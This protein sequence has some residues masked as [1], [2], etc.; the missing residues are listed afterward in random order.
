MN[1][2]T[3]TATTTTTTINDAAPT[4]PTDMVRIQTAVNKLNS[5]ADKDDLDAFIRGGRR[6]ILLVDVS[7]SMT[8]R[9]RAGGRKIDALRKVVTTLR[10]TH[11]V[12]VAAF[13]VNDSYTGVA[14]IDEVPEPQGSTPMD[15]AID[16]GREQGANHLVIV[17][18]GQPNDEHSTMRAAKAFGNP[19]DVFYVG[20]GSGR[21]FAKRLATM[22][23]GE[24]QNAD[25]GAIKALA[26]GIRLMLGDGTN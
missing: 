2:T 21:E 16:F 1:N 9:L 19:I 25:L 26:S 8:D 15:N 24:F 23:G 5:S 12:P 14:L 20:D 10:E 6:S 13:G 18:D 3:K 4:T 7:F 17:T 11:P 22:T